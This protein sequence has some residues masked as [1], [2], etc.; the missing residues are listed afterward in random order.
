MIE[1]F[2]VITAQGVG[3]GMGGKIGKAVGMA[4]G[5]VS[6]AT[7]RSTLGENGEAGAG[8]SEWVKKFTATIAKHKV[9]EREDLAEKIVI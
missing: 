4:A 1:N 5:A 2:G 6:G 3:M 7:T 8:T 9:W